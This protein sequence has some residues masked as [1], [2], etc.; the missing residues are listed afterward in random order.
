MGV[1][2][3]KNRILTNIMSAMLVSSRAPL[4]LWGKAILSTYHLQNKSFNK[5]KGKRLYELWKS[6][7]P[8]LRYLKM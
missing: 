7:S 1:V 3:R 2:E 5:K 4:K 8:N 6:Y